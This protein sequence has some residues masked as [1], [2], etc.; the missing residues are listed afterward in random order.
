MDEIV[1]KPGEDESAPDPLPGPTVETGPASLDVQSAA[2]RQLDPKYVQ[3]QRTVGWI[4]TA[5]LSFSL[6]AAAGVGW[7]AARPPQWLSLS[8]LPAWFLATGAF[9]WLLQ[10]WPAVQYRHTHYTVSP[11][12]IEIQSGVWW[13]H[14]MSVPRSR[15]QHIDVSQGPIERSYGLG[16]LVIFTAGTEHSRIELPGLRDGVAYDLRNHLLPRGSDDAV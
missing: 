15:V 3:L 7:L 8:L 4:A 13:R 10:A 1:R 2:T 11:E 5:I 6:L 14:L 16:R 9:A 12:G